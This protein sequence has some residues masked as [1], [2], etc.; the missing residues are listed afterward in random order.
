[1][2]PRVLDSGFGEILKQVSAWRL[3]ELAVGNQRGQTMSAK[4]LI[5][6]V[7]QSKI[8]EGPTMG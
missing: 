1:M 5:A 7:R 3:V 2:L 8:E 4:Y 6:H